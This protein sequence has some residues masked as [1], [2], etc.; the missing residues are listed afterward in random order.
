MYRQAHPNALNQG[1][2]LVVPWLRLP[3]GDVRV[4]TDDPKPGPPPKCEE[5]GH[6]GRKPAKSKRYTP[7]GER[8]KKGE[9]CISTGCDAVGRLDSVVAILL[10]HSCAVDTRPSLSF[11]PLQPIS[12]LS[13]AEA[14]AARGARQPSYLLLPSVGGLPEAVADLNMRFSLPATAV[15]RR[16]EHK[17]QPV[18]IPFAEATASRIA[19]LS[20]NGLKVLYEA[21]A[22]NDSRQQATVQV[23]LLPDCVND[24]PTRPA[25][26]TLGWWWPRPAW[27]GGAKADDLS[28][29]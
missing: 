10:S 6:E 15:G 29:A 12:S 23:T 22:R 13:S 20:K 2:I 9:S 1:D 5:C 26:V 19:S 11:A 21:L 14:E 3:S 28:V 16:A 4:V 24:D 27:L 25:T 18:L 17:G 8:I 7:A